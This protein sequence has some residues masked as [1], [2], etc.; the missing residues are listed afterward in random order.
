MAVAKRP[1]WPFA[2]CEELVMDWI[3]TLDAGSDGAVEGV[4]E[5]EGVFRLVNWLGVRFEEY[6]G[7]AR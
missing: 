3:R 6:E 1:Y 2:G 5:G 7:F 4:S